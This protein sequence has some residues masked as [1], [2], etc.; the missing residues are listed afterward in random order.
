MHWNWKCKASAVGAVLLCTC[1]VVGAM[2]AGPPSGSTPL[3]DPTVKAPTALVAGKVDVQKPEYST[4]NTEA[5]STPIK[6]P[7]PI[8]TITSFGTDMPGLQMTNLGKELPV[9]S[10]GHDLR[11]GAAAEKG[12]RGV[13]VLYAPTEADNSAWRAE[14]STLLGG[15]PVDYFDARVDTPSVAMMEDYA[16]VLTWVNY[17][18]SDNVLMGDNLADYVDAGGKVILGQWCIH[19]N[20]VNWLLGRIMEADYCPITADSYSTTESCYTGDGT[21]CIHLD[22]A[23]DSYCS[24]YRDHI[25]GTQGYGMLDG[26]FGDGYWT[27]GYQSAGPAQMR[28]FYSAGNTGN[29][30]G[31]GA[32]WAEV[33]ANMVLICSPEPM[34]GACCN[35]LTGECIDNVELLDC[36]D[37]P[38]FDRWEWNT[39]CDDLDPPCGQSI[40]AC[41]WGDE[42]PHFYECEDDMPLAECLALG[43][44]TTWWEDESCYDPT[45]ECPGAPSYCDPC[46]SNTT[47]DWLANVTFNEINNTTGIEGPPCSYGDYRYLQAFVSPGTTVPLEVSVGET[48][49]WTQCVSAWVD[50]NQDYEFDESTERYTGVCGTDPDLLFTQTID[51]TVPGDALPGPTVMRVMEKYYSMPVDACEVYTYGETEDYSVFVGE[52]QGGCCIDYEPY[53]FDDVLEGDCGDMGGTFLGHAVVCS[54][55]DCN[56]NGVPDNCDI[57]TGTSADCQPDGVPDECQCDCNGNGVPDDCDIADGTSPD[58]NENGIPDEC[59]VPPLCDPGA[60]CF[61]D[62]CSYDVD[63]NGVPDECQEDCNGNG[64]LDLCDISCDFGDCATIPGCGLSPDCQ[65][66]GI[67]DDCQV[68]PE[69]G[70]GF[71]GNCCWAHSAPGCED[72]ACEAS[73]CSYDSYCCDVQWDTLCAMEAADDMNC[74]CVRSLGRDVTY[75]HDDGIHEDSIGLTAG[76]YVA[77]MNHFVTVEDGGTITEI[78]ISY[79]MVNQG[80]A[81]TV[82]LWSDPNQDGDPTDGQVL[83]SVDSEVINPDSDFFVVVDIPDTTVGEPGTHFFVGAMIYHPAG[84]YPCAIDMTASAGQSWIAGDGSVPI[85]PDNLGAAALPPGVIDDLGFPGNWL[86]R[87]VGSVGA[88]ADCNGNC[89]PDDCDIMYCYQQPPEEQWWCLDCNNNGCPDEGDLPGNDCDENLVPDDCQIAE[90]P[91]DD[92]FCQDCDEDGI[93]DGCQLEGNDCQGDL[94]PDNCQLEDNDCNG[95]GI[96]DEC[97]V[98]PIC[99]EC[100]DCEP[101]GIPDDCAP[102]CN[103]NGIPD[104]CDIRDCDTS[105]PFEEHFWC[106]DCQPDGFP[107]GCQIGWDCDTGT[108]DSGDCCYDHY[109]EPGCEDPECEASVCSY[110]SFCCNV[111]WDSLCADEAHSDPNCICEE[112][113]GKSSLDE[114]AILYAPTQ[115]DDAAFR[116]EVAAITGG[117]VDYFD[118]RSA[119][120]GLDL[121][122]NY[123]LVYTWVNYAYAD[124]VAMGDVLADYVDAGGRVVLGQWCIHT[125]QVNWLEGRIMDPAEGYLPIS[126][127]GYSSGTYSGDGTGCFTEGVMSWYSPYRDDAAL[128]PGAET[129]GTYTDGVPFVAFYDGV[130]V[131]YMPGV[132][133]GGFGE[134]GDKAQL[135][136]NAL[137]CL[138]GPSGED[139]N[140]NC[141]PD[142]CDIAYCD[143]SYWCSDCNEND[144]PD[145]CEPDCNGNEQADECDIDYGI[146][147]DCNDNGIPDECDVPPLCE[148]GEYGFP[149]ECSADCQPD[150]V[151]DECQLEDNDCNE[152]EVPDECDIADG[153]SED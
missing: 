95:N 44:T 43:E 107:D 78:H 66:D 104:F 94:I 36:I 122:M 49:A 65:P 86:I 105:T 98:P 123:G 54:P 96:P 111:G 18:Y 106:L 39:L 113:A 145:G 80:T 71:S 93:L 26:T 87:A 119:T 115:P 4:P 76:G 128:L 46:F 40:G 47:D 11:R 70:E 16:A 149:E 37:M 92:P 58:C 88:V 83:A 24:S 63:G 62:P 68:P 25:T 140:W 67:P 143:G 12:A 2:T 27:H 146:S 127:T 7:T 55:L 147:E 133:S 41:C 100:P 38:G 15:A 136:A 84:Q 51:I 56:D 69:C 110:D 112:G 153:T 61:P 103:E 19:T 64:I 81:T 131:A 14:L 31:S 6:E 114:D 82:I 45:F 101:D 144:I 152:N 75:Q 9:R 129:D 52:A 132:L 57:A 120:P 72:P 135:I 73:V 32:G 13:G 150:I 22:V 60:E 74:D 124:N 33:V 48:Y 5:A 130:S 91:P 35:E 108:P 148:P 116:A 29:T 151:P 77:W 21:S 118:P 89:I 23:A 8:Q 99:P 28:C 117:A 79:G 3:P 125:N 141:I 139:C 142:D 134:S 137:P 138:G 85:D 1:L 90:C 53:C 20:Q 42:P 59:D 126:A 121:L 109:P 17:A 34:Y 97:E 10:T 50:W 30:Y 102:D